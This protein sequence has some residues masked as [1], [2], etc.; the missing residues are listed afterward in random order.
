MYPN[1]VIVNL[2]LRSRDYGNTKEIVKDVGNGNVIQCNV[3]VY[4]MVNGKIEQ[5]QRL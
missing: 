5:R 1:Q 4:G 2:M 3:K